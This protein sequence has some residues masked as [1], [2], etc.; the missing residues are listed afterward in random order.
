VPTE[1][2][3]HS[4]QVRISSSSYVYVVYVSQVPR[5]PGITETIVHFHIDKA[6]SPPPNTPLFPHHIYSH[7]WNILGIP[8][9]HASRS[10]T[11]PLRKI[12]QKAKIFSRWCCEGFLVASKDRDVQDL[13]VL[14][15]TLKGRERHCYGRGRFPLGPG[16]G[17]TIWPEIGM[18]EWRFG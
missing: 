6:N 10:L 7:V 5:S 2:I 1:R 18:C 15:G 13:T 3:D 12:A 17:Y 11:N 4:F 14:L 9:G 16:I 8:P